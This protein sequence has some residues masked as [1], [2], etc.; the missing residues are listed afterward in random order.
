MPPENA[1]PDTAARSLAHWSE[2]GRREM[3]AF[4]ALARLD[5]QLLA[6]ALDYPEL[7]RV[8]RERAGGG[9][10]SLLDVACGSGKFPETLLER[11]ELAAQDDLRVDYDLLD[12]APFSLQEAAAVL[13]PPF[14]EAARHEV[15]MEDLDPAVGPFDVVWATHALYALQPENVD[16]AA[17]RMLDA[18]APHGVLLLAQGAYDGHYLAFYRAFLEGVRGGEGTAY[19]SCEQLT[20]ALGRVG[21]DDTHEVEVRRIS[22]EHVVAD[23]DR[24]VLEGFLQRCAFDDTVSLEQM[25]EAPVLGAYLEACH[26]ADAGVHRFRQETDLVLLTPND[27]TPA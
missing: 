1:V 11:T 4:Y 19:V 13:R 26:D 5:Y 25:R 21:A 18:L 3:E 14:H 23:D 27:G 8:V 17:R 10:V 22:Y 15:T 6:D 7:F 20:D 16:A 12:P 2:E 24:E 9:A